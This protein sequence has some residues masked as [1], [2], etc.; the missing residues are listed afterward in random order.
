LDVHVWGTDWEFDSIA[1]W[2]GCLVYL[3]PWIQLSVKGYTFLYKPVLSLCW[4][5]YFWD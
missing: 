2:G 3:N 5:S 1:P 4:F